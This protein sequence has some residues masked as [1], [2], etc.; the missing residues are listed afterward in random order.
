MK[1][2]NFDCFKGTMEAIYLFGE[3]YLKFCENTLNKLIFYVIEKKRSVKF[4][5]YIETLKLC[6]LIS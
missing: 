6:F 2:T 1:I 3:T 5:R 4:F